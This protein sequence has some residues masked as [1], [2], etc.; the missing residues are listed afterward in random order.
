MRFKCKQKKSADKENADANAAGGGD[1]GFEE[2][3]VEA[4]PVYVDANEP[5]G[6]IPEFSDIEV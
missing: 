2:G 1:G 6:G 5:D 3:D 4:H